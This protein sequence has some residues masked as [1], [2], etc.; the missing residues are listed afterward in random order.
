MRD[1]NPLRRTVRQIALVPQRHRVEGRGNEAPHDTHERAH[2]LR[3]DRILLLRHRRTPDLALSLE[4]LR[5]LPDFGPLEIP[6]LGAELLE[7]R[8]EV[9]EDANELRMSIPADDL[10]RGLLESDP[11][12]R[13]H[14][15][16]NVE[17]LG[18]ERGSRSDGPGH[19]ADDD[20]GRGLSHPF[21]LP[22]DLGGEDR[23][24]ESE[25]DRYGGLTMRAAEHDRLLVLRRQVRECG[26]ENNEALLNDADRVPELEGG[27]TVLNVVARRP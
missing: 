4:R 15:S 10:G 20:S 24:L 22:R 6:H 2:V 12:L 1:E 17:G 25:R 5:H 9:R 14:G 27:R 23:H 21:S 19:L 26:Y 11:E 13:H 3:G 18:T 16:L 8:G 7:G